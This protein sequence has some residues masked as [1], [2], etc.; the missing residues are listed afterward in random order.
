VTLG[1]SF[2]NDLLTDKTRCPGDDHLH[3]QC[4]L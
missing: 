3:F 1:Q 2:I 4:S